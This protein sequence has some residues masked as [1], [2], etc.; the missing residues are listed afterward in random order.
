M[1]ATGGLA[2]RTSAWAQPARL[3]M[4]DLDA[5]TVVVE[6]DPHLPTSA[7]RLPLAVGQIVLAVTSARGV[8][9]VAFFA[10]GEPVQVPLPVGALTDGP[11]T[12]SDYAD[13]VVGE[14]SSSTERWPG[15]P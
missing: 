12:A 9:A 3:E 1:D 6:L 7:E 13:L 8:G 5:R 10:D 14:R 15:C 4:V 2:G 11:V